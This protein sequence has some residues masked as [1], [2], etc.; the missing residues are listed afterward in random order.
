MKV[1]VTVLV[2]TKTKVSNYLVLVYREHADDP[3]SIES[4][5]RRR[6]FGSERYS[7]YSQ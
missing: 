4:E 1:E 6:G 5:L 3:R 2:D 7:Y